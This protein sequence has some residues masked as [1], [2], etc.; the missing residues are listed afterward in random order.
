MTEKDERTDVLLYG[1]RKYNIKLSFHQVKNMNGHAVGLKFEDSTGSMDSSKTGVSVS[2]RGLARAIGLRA[3]E[4][5]GDL[6]GV[7]FFGFYLLTDGLNE[8]QI[9]LKD[10][11]YSIQAKEMHKAVKDTLPHGIKI[12]VEGGIGWGMSRYEPQTLPQ[13][14]LFLEELGKTIRESALC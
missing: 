9:R 12:D 11:L 6:R 3:V 10:A 1:G 14:Q 5:M 8:R 2:G 13:M 7:D 4:M